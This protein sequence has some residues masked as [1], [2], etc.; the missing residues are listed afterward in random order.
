V[1]DPA[2]L[3]ALDARRLI[4]EKALSPLELWQACRARID[5]WNPKVNAVV[6]LDEEAGLA[7]AREAE[8]AVTQGAALGPLHGL[9][10]GIKDLSEVRGLRTT[11]GSELYAE[12]IPAYDDGFV[13]RLRGAGAILAAKTN[14]PEFGAGANTWNRVFGATGNPYAPE[15]TCGGSSGG[16]AVALACGMTPL[17]TGS[18]LGGS[19]RT[20]AAFCGVYG[21]R[22]TPGLVPDETPGRA[23]SPLSVEGPVARSVAD[24]HLLLSVMAAHDPR[25]PWSAPG[26]AESVGKPLQARDPK[27]LRVAF[28][29]DLGFA[30]VSKQTRALFAERMGRLEPLFGSLEEA[31]PPLRDAVRLFQTLRGVGFVAAHLD[32][33]RLAPEKVGPNVTANVQQGLALST[34]EIARAEADW[35]ALYRRFLSFRSRYDLFLAPAAAL[36]PFPKAQNAPEEI[37][38][39]PLENYVSWLGLAFGITLTSHP[40][41]AF[42]CG[43]DAAGL[44]FGIQLVGT[45]QGDHALLEMALGLEKALA[46]ETGLT[47]VE[48]K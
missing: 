24:I 45:R 30:P 40:S 16:S 46:G 14:T 38:G 17:A 34:E 20:P 12:N 32:R 29:A 23:F 3:S 26:L 1:T 25:D 2:D 42:P 4:G 27:A 19:L 28:S 35:A 21:F 36:Q 9:P 31:D 6:T 7:A 43:T 5:A 41:L 44:P 18:D 22:P 39:E 11:Y 8:S 37:D 15:L 48:P 47:R 10:V 13:A 33:L